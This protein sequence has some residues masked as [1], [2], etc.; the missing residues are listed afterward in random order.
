MLSFLDLDYLFVIECSELLKPGVRIS[1]WILG[2]P[3]WTR[4]FGVSYPVIGCFVPATI[5][6]CNGIK[7]VFSFTTL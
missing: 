7:D 6:N 5:F 3:V 2:I 4:L 1:I